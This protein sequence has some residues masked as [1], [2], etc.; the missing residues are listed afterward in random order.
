MGSIGPQYY[1]DEM[2]DFFRRVLRR[3]ADARL[4]LLTPAL[5][6]AR[7]VLERSGIELGRVVL[8]SVS[9]SG[10][11]SQ[12]PAADLGLALRAPTFS[13]QG[14]SPVKIAEYLLCGVPAL[15]TP[16]GDLA[17]QLEPGSGLL[18]DEPRAE[19]LE[20]AAR[21][22]VES[23]LPE[24]DGFRARCR[25]VGLSHFALEQGVRRY[26][27]AL[28]YACSKPGGSPSAAPRA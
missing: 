4:V 26:A 21:W 12:I 8:R 14:I 11:A 3:R 24:R 17:T 23:V 18:I 10:I 16:I 22:F 6:A 7:A 20:R 28:R 1:P 27:E 25:E 9:P 5:D 15:A 13:Q 19:E 2:L